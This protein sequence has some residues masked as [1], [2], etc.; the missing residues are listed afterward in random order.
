[1]SEIYSLKIRRARA[2]GVFPFDR[3]YLVPHAEREV[4][5]KMFRY[6]LVMPVMGSLATLLKKAS[7]DYHCFRAHERNDDALVPV[8]YYADQWADFVDNGSFIMVIPIH[9]ASLT[10]KDPVTYPTY[11]AAKGWAKLRD[12]SGPHGIRRRAGFDDV[13]NDMVPALSY[14]LTPT[15]MIRPICSVCPRFIHHQ[16]GR[17][18]IGEKICFSSLPLGQAAPS[19]VPDAPVDERAILENP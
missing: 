15:K 16:A 7:P 6:A 3:V 1:M 14:L 17:C 11:L 5:P 10:S 8:E 12:S 4:I 19:K 18:S 9:P 2:K 13:L